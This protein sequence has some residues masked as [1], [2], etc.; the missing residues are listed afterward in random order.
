MDRILIRSAWLILGAFCHCM[1]SEPAGPK[2]EHGFP[3]VRYTI[4]HATIDV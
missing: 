4:L 2:G 3:P 1:K